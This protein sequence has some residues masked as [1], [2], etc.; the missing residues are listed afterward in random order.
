MLA[1]YA[2]RSRW[3]WLN[4]PGNWLMAVGPTPNNS[5]SPPVV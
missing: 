4:S 5:S 3:F 1:P 2:F